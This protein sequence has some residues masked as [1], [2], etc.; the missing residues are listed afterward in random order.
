MSFY[1]DGDNGI[2]VQSTLDI[3][4]S[5]EKSKSLDNINSLNDDLNSYP[6]NS[7]FKRGD[8]E[9]SKISVG[10]PSD[11]Y[12]FIYGR[13]DKCMG[14]TQDLLMEFFEDAISKEIHNMRED[15]VD[16]TFI[17]TITLPHETM[18]KLNGML[19]YHE[20]KGEQFSPIS[21]DDFIVQMV[22]ELYEI[23]RDSY[24]EKSDQLSRIM[25]GVNVEQH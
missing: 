3:H 18:K 17:E 12:D 2:D 16:G 6:S 23:R 8:I 21:L 11:D 10:I 7:S 4:I 15:G 5:H 14:N 24:V 20:T 9:Y 22:D 1:F 19:Y 25:E 13:F